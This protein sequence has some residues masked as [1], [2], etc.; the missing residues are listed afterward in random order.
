MIGKLDRVGSAGGT[1]RSLRSVGRV[2]L[3]AVVVLLLIHGAVSL[4]GSGRPSAVPAANGTDSRAAQ[5]SAVVG[6]FAV[7]YVRA[8]L[9]DSSPASVAKLTVPGTPIPQGGSVAAGGEAVAQA[10]ASTTRDLGNGRAVV[11]VWCELTS[12]RVLYLAVPTI[13]D[14]AGGVAALGPPAFVAAPGIGRVESEAERS[15][16]IPGADAEELRELAQRFVSS[17]LSG[18]GPGDLKYLTAPQSSI[19]ALGGFHA[20]GSVTVRQLGPTRPSARTV[21]ASVRAEGEGGRVF[22][23]AYRLRLVR[24]DRWYVSAVE[25]EVL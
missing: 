3:W 18:A 15:Q 11:T 25:G 6:S 24:R 14:G 16:P 23:L 7:R 22:P 19:G 8:Y 9:A 17:Y 20:V 5:R 12:G 4:V 13:R 10:E 2:A 21:V 1:S